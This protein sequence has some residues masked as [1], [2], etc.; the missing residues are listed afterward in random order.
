MFYVYVIKS[1]KDGRLYK[2]FTQNLEARVK[3]HN[4]GNTRSTKP[5]IPWQLVYYETFVNK[6]EA[7]AREKFL[8]TGQG[9]D[10]YRFCLTVV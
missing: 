9:W 4:S 2:G 5:F 1:E 3:G 10:F 6:E 7:L 8:K